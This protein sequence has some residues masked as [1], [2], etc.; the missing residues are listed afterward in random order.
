MLEIDGY[1]HCGGGFRW[2]NTV[3]VILTVSQERFARGIVE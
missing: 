2:R 1:P 3:R